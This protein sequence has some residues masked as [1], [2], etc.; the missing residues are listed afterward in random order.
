MGNFIFLIDMNY[1]IKICFLIIIFFITVKSQD[2]SEL[3]YY[4]KLYS[5]EY[6]IPIDILKAVAYTETRFYHHVP[7]STNSSCSGIPHSYGIMGLRNDN[8]FGYSLIEASKLIN[9]S[10]EELIV[11]FSKNIKGA[12]ALLSY[13]AN[14]LKINRNALNEW[15]PV[16][17]KYSGIPQN[18]VKEF[19]SFDA[20]KVLNE[21]TNLNGIEIKAHPEI[22]MQLFDENVN[23]SN[24]LKNIE[25][26][27]YPPA[28]WDPSPN[29]TA[30][31]ITQL[32]AVVHSTEG[33]FAGALS[34]LKNPSSQASSHYIIRSSDGYIVQLV[35]ERDKAWH[36]RC[37]NG[38]MLG[39][40]HEGFVA[41]PA[42]FTEVM[43][44]SSAAL[45]KHFATKFS[46]PIN[47]FRI[48]A[49]GEWQ[50][51]NWKSWM[52]TNYPSIDPTC[53][54]HTDPGVYWKWDRYMALISGQDSM[55]I[56]GFEYVTSPWWNPTT[57]GSTYGIS[58]TSTF[59][60][61]YESKKGGTYS[62]KLTLKDSTQTSNWFVRVYYNY[63]SKDTMKLGTTG[64]L[65]I[66]LKSS[67]IPTG[68][69]VRL[70]VDD[71]SSSTTEVTTWQTVIA[72]GTWHMYEWKI[73]DP[74]QWAAWVGGANG[75][76]DGPNTFFDSIQFQCSDPN[77]GSAEYLIYFDNIEKGTE[78]LNVISLNLTAL[79]EGFYNNTTNKMVRD[80]ITVLLRNTASPYLVVDSNK[81]YLD[82]LGN[83]V[84]K[85]L[86]ASSGS[87]YIVLKHR[88]HIETWSKSGGESLSKGLTTSYNFT[89]NSSKAFGNNLKLKG[90][91]WCI[92][93]GD[94]SQD[95]IADLFD[96]TEIDNDMFNVSSGYRDTDLT[97]DYIVNSSDLMLC[98][99]NAFN[100]VHVAKPT[101]IVMKETKKEIIE[102]TNEKNETN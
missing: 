22:N 25:S 56:H 87:Y 73:D 85:F 38:Y 7:D 32:F 30:N 49:H 75:Q 98:H 86:S 10:A 6:N 96:L 40:E 35:R 19:Y 97:G 80:T 51:S 62:G 9:A 92:L 100:Y 36:A 64:Y 74:N 89:D 33:S 20:F 76:I 11:D 93:A 66:Y 14:Q 31:N 34:W 55:V 84:V 50:N 24:K 78:P 41:N 37:W 18:D 99:N 3:N 39:V 42:Y 53:N 70:A 95:G 65:R 29:Y 102:K 43:Y 91:K 72:D 83:G 69:K 16:L 46:I 15:K 26:D 58:K 67:S 1:L 45:F 81:V 27:D 4:F 88:N 8:W 44:Q 90:T 71:N 23:P 13:F 47:R 5:E 61:T 21:G 94:V 60:Q 28:V 77:S 82:S 68:L 52:Q 59:K 12:A 57:S 63:S 2:S 79:L 48:V 17:E 54:T 101:E